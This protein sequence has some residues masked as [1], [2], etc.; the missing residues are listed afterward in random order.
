MLL[1]KNYKQ[2][3]IFS[4][5]LSLPIKMHFLQ[6]PASP[7]FFQYYL[8]FYAHFCHFYPS[9]DGSTLCDAVQGQFAFLQQ[10]ESS[11]GQTDHKRWISPYSQ[12]MSRNQRK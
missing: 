8:L 5:H 3:C 9:K 7:F 12:L 2:S 10:T 11:F 1:Y 4:P 6:K